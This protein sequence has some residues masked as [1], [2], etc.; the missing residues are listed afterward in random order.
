MRRT[1]ET[2][3]TLDLEEEERLIGLMNLLPFENTQKTKFFGRECSPISLLG[4]LVLPYKLL[5]RI[6]TLNNPSRG[7]LLILRVLAPP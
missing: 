3:Q 4:A 2:P 7:A 6:I 1:L 5:G